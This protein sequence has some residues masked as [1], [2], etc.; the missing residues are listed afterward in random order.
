M[1]ESSSCN[2]LTDWLGQGYDIYA[3]G[4]QEC[5]DINIFE[6]ELNNVLGSTYYLMQTSIGSV[7]FYVFIILGKYFIRLSW[8]YWFI[9]IYK[10]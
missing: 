3:I 1:N 9:F 6:E 10:S 4:V 7:Y 8:I 2:Q 5:L